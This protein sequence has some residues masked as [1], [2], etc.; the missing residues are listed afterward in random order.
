MHVGH[1][2]KVMEEERQRGQILYLTHGRLFYI[3]RPY[4]HGT[5]VDNLYFHDFK[6]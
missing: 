4:L 5:V 2:G 1:D 3:V 6:L